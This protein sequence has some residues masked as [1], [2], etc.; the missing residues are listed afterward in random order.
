[1]AVSLA[2]SD[3]GVVGIGLGGDEARFAPSLFVEAFAFA[4]AHGLNVVAHAGEAAG[5]DSVRHAVEVLGAQRIGH[6]IRALEDD[7]VIALLRRRGITLECAPTSNVRTGVVSADARHP[8]VMLDER[9]VN[10]TVDADD[11]ALFGTSVTRELQLV[12]KM[13][14]EH[15]VVRFVRNAVDASFADPWR[16]AALHAEIDG[17]VGA[18]AGP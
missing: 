11:P 14:G 10:V 2:Q 17:A 3:A 7:G 18:R 1:M 9:G 16:K 13:V 12:E 15:D 6:G 5:A 4:R 8:L